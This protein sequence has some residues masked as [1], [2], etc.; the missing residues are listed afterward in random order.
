MTP[1]E[2]I[3]Q[4]RFLFTPNASPAMGETAI[5]LVWECC[6]VLRQADTHSR[7]QIREIELWAPIFYSERKWEQ[8]PGGQQFIAGR[9][10][11]ACRVVET[12][13]NDAKGGTAP[14]G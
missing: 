11:S 1:E 6:F 8:Y 14:N 10:L 2:A 13:L 7:N 9:V 3:R 12:D 5:A 4:I